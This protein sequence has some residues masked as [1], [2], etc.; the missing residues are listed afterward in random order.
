MI[1]YRIARKEGLC[2][3]LATASQVEGKIIIWCRSHGIYSVW[4]TLRPSCWIKLRFSCLIPQTSNSEGSDKISLTERLPPLTAL[5]AFEAAARHMSFAKAAEELYVTPAAL[6]YQIKS[7]ETDM[8]QPLFRRLNRAVEL[9]EAG[10][11]LAPGVAEGFEALRAA[12]RQAHRV[13]ESRP[14]SVTAGPAFTAKWLAPRIY[15]FV[16]QHPDIEIR[17]TAS[18]KRMNFDT[19]DV[20]AAIR[21]SRIDEEPGCYVETLVEELMTPLCTPEIAAQLKT[22]SDLQNF[23]L[24]HDESLSFMAEPPNWGFWLSA[25]GVEFDWNH[26]PRFSNADQVLGAAVG[27]GGVA[28]GRLSLAADDMTA[29]RLVAPFDLA[30]DTGAHFNFVCL[31]GHETRREEAAFLAWMRE[32]LAGE[33]A[34][35]EGMRII[36]V[37]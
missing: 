30:I 21:F 32:E 34:Y 22:P 6:S 11:A 1:R 15:R 7:L 2:A 5:R 8:S 19:D 17:F 37:S 14:F 26:G 33:G 24:V 29:G 3:Q 28:L 25:V 23:R 9:T 10:R 27:G 16:E 35:G 31:E 13:N 36:T 12:V 18:L 4:R 20:D